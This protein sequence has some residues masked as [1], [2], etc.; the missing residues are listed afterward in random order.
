MI[1][2]LCLVGP[3]PRVRD[4]LLVWQASGVTTLLAKAGDVETVRLLAEATS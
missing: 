1:D 3:V 4:R 2:E